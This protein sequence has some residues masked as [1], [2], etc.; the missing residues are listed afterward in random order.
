MLYTEKDDWRKVIEMLNKG[1]AKGNLEDKAL[2]YVNKG[3]AQINLGKCSSG[4]NTLKKATKYKSMRSRANAWIA[5][6]EE[7]KKNNKCN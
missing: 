1:L 3:V 2:A 5:Y 4:I 6:A 7:K